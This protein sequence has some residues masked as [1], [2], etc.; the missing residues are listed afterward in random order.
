M[1][2]LLALWQADSGFPSGSFAFSGGLEGYFAL[3]P[4]SDD[5]AGVL[6]DLLAHR[7]ATSDRVALTQAHRA[8]GD[9]AAIAAAD[10][11][12][13]A[14]TL[15]Q[16]L[17]DGSRRNGAAFLSAHARIGTAMA[18]TL[19]AACRHGSCLGHLAVMQGAVFGALGM[20]PQSAIAAS[21]Y[22]AAASLVTAA[23]RLGRVGAM[24]GQRALAGVLPLLSELAATPPDTHAMPKGF[25]P[26]LDIA[27]ARHPRASMRLFA[28]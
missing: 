19:R 3:A 26:F 8:N 20:A 18:D 22:A 28:T 10:A 12:L 25:V 21:G 16:S 11:A 1:I 14:A 5:V 4:D 13:E 2:D 6:R 23:V 9:L 17:R 15:I 27:A 7:W 24:Q